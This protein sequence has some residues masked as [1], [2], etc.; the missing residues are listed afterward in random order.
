MNSVRRSTV[1]RNSK[2]KNFHS[3]NCLSEPADVSDSV[4]FV[5]IRL[6]LSH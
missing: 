1:I 2:N 4:L 3:K 6:H 5:L